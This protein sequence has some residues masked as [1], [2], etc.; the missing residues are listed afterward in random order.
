[1]DRKKIKEF[2]WKFYISEYPDLKIAGI[3]TKYLAYK[4]WINHGVKEERISKNPNLNIS[5]VEPIEINK[6]SKKYFDTEKFPELFCKYHLKIADVNQKIN[7]NI[8][9]NIKNKWEKNISHIHI[10]DLS[11]FYD[12]EKIINNLEMCSSVIITTVIN[13]EKIPISNYNGTH[14]L[15]IKNKGLDIG[16]K[17]AAV[18]YLYKNNI[19]FQNML[20]LH[21]KS[22]PTIRKI[23]FDPLVK[24][25]DRIKFNFS[26]MSSASDLEGIF[27]DI[28]YEKGTHCKYNQNQVID[29]LKYL[30]IDSA[31]IND[32]TFAEGNCLYIKKSLIDFIFKDR[33]EILYNSLNEN[34]SFDYNWVREYYHYNYKNV[35]TI[36]NIYVKK[37]LYGNNI[38]L[39]Y[40]KDSFRDAMFEHIF[41]RI[42]IECIKFRRTKYLFLST[43]PV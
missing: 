19:D 24:N 25:L 8:I 14:I 22:D 33:I 17:I 38:P 36:Y 3:N 4:H 40:G 10:Y 30:G 39:M 7:Y 15:E 9:K 29:F 28:K 32:L 12:Y 21:S 41:E 5:K 37:K 26:L 13:N 1:M 43:G 2:D 23:Y 20:F 16:G 18:D 42:W 31:N 27:P 35:R 6:F 34:N 11:Q